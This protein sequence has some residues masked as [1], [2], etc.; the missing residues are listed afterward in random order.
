MSFLREPTE[1]HGTAE[2]RTLAAFEMNQNQT[3]SL[4]L[5]TCRRSN[6][7]VLTSDFAMPDRYNA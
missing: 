4:W 3:S 5:L 2:G 7:G 1:G 6:K